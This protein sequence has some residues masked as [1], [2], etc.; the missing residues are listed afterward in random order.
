MYHE[1]HQVELP[2]MSVSR[3]ANQPAPFVKHCVR[4]PP[5]G[6]PF[7][8]GK[9]ENYCSGKKSCS[10]SNFSIGDQLFGDVDNGRGSMNFQMDQH[11][12]DQ[13]I[14]LEVSFDDPFHDDWPHW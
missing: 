7:V 9:D 11:P 4:T 8:S 5:N 14:K 6:H 13:D 2:A 1:P 12:I 3:A 10:T